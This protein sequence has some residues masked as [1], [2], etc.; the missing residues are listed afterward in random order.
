MTL[1]KTGDN[2]NPALWAAVTVSS[3]MLILLVLIRR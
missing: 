1:P 3:L 2:D